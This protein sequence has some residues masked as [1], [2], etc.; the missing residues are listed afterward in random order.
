MHIEKTVI[1]ALI[2]GYSGT[3]KY[4]Y[5]KI[6]FRNLYIKRA[7]YKRKLNYD[8]ILFHEG[9]VNRVDQILIKFLSAN[10]TIKFIYVREFFQIPKNVLV[11][12]VGNNSLGYEMMCVFHYLRVWA[13]LKE[14]DIAIRIDDD[15]L[16]RDLPS[17]RKDQIFCTAVVS[18]ETHAETKKTLPIFLKQLGDGAFYDDR[19]PYTNVYITRVS[20]WLRDDV[21]E[22]LLNFFMNQY[23]IINRWGD[24]PIIGVTLKKYGAWNYESDI[25]DNFAYMHLSHSSV[26]ENGEIQLVQNSRSKLFQITARNL[27]KWSK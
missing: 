3:K 1:F 22:Y 17:L 4:H 14:Y 9:N 5:L 18:D 27:V 26:V 24:L 19:F 8:L 13:Y 12:E 20:F 16:V 10:F 21:Q 15:C 23:S 6:I 11:T 25:L 7:N 2:R